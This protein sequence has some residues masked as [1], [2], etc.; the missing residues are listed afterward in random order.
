[1]PVYVTER[2]KAQGLT[3][4]PPPAPDLFESTAS[5][6]RTVRAEIALGALQSI[7]LG[8]RVSIAQRNEAIV[9]RVGLPGDTNGQ[10]PGASYNVRQKENP[11]GPQILR[12]NGKEIRI[13]SESGPENLVLLV[14][15]S[16]DATPIIIRAWNKSIRGESYV[17]LRAHSRSFNSVND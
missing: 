10:G 8:L 5:G 6:P 7:E 15:E 11:T 3:E 1:M 14:R 9:V 16:P 12:L 4:A 2:G 13:G 17:G